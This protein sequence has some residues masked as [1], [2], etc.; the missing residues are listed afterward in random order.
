MK[1]SDLLREITATYQKFGWIL[2]GALLT[3]AAQCELSGNAQTLISENVPIE[4]SEIN[5]VWFSR[6]CGN[7]ETW[8]L[9]LLSQSAFALVE[10]FE[11][12]TPESERTKR[13]EMITEKMRAN[14]S[15][16]KV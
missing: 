16:F 11:Q 13:R 1:L 15:K 10:T 2:R 3:E 6:V 4:N 12:T 9:R 8:E 14:A 5:A 7:R